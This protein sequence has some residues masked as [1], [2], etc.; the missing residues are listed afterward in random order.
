MRPKPGRVSDDLSPRPSP[1]SAL[2]TQHFLCRLLVLPSFLPSFRVP[3][4]SPVLRGRAVPTPSLADAELEE[5]WAQGK[6][7]AGEDAG[8]LQRA[9]S[10]RR[11]ADRVRWLSAAISCPR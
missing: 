10:G 5:S 11:Q 3:G 7:G 8:R 1:L 9:G 4:L 6:K 2:C